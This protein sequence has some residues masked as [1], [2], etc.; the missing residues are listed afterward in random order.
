MDDSPRIAAAGGRSRAGVVRLA[1]VVGSLWLTAAIFFVAAGRVAVPRAWI[2]YGGLLAYLVL[3]MLVLFALFP[4]V[5]DTIN[6]RGKLNRDVERWDKLFGLGYMALL[7]VQPAVAGL[8]LRHAASAAF[9]PWMLGPALA[10]TLLAYA[11]VHWAM[12]VN[13][14]AETGVR[15]QHDRQHVVASTGPYRFV[16]HP[17]YAALIVVNLAYPLALGSA[18]AYLPSL[19]MVVLFV[20][21]TAREDALLV[22][23]LEGYAAFAARTRYRLLPGVW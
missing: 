22:R 7:L 18:W 1:T 5:S 2:Y 19:A 11:F 15:I 16:R 21:R 12:V 10:L 17:F 23:E 9:P 6:A 13:R 20:W 3:A 8:E 14:H 4:G